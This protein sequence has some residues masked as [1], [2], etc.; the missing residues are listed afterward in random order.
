MTIYLQSPEKTEIKVFETENQIGA[1]FIDWIKLTDKEITAYLLKQAKESKTKELESF[2]NSQECWVFKIYTQNDSLTRDANFF[3]KVLP[4]CAGRSIQLLNDK[5]EIVNYNLTV[6][7]ASNLNYEIN[8]VKSLSIKAKKLALENQ[9]ELSN[10][11][12]DVNNIDCKNE[13]LN[14]VDRNINLDIV[15]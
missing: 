4:A 1:G 9:I 6:E 10:N 8:A 13:L 5:N 12:D 3:A 2:Y 14:A 15:K 11:I 7:K